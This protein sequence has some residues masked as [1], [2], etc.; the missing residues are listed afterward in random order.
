M[1]VIANQESKNDTGKGGY[2]PEKAPENTLNNEEG[3]QSKDDKIK[4]IHGYFL[5]KAIFISQVHLN[6]TWAILIFKPV[7]SRRAGS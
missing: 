5:P 6:L 7:A 2:F 3:Y 4:N 1:I